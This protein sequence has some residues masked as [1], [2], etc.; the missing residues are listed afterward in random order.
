MHSSPGPALRCHSLCT[1]DNGENLSKLWWCKEGSLYE[2][3]PYGPLKRDSQ[4]WETT[5]QR[6]KVCLPAAWPS[7]RLCKEAG[8]KNN[9]CVL[10]L[11]TS[12]TQIH[13]YIRKEEDIL[14]ALCTLL[15]EIL[16]GY[17][18]PSN[19]NTPINSHFSMLKSTTITGYLGIQH[20]KM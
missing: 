10:L 12:G 6:T 18:D 8:R 20:I 4:S 1:S 17:L 16:F 14:P 11:H 9:Y 15:G 19:M 3:L 5:Q 7:S 2:I 13:C